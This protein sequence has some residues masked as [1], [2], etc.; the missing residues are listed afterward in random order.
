MR[1][2][3]EIAVLILVGAIPIFGDRIWATRHTPNKSEDSGEQGSHTLTGKSPSFPEPDFNDAGSRVV[4]ACEGAAR[5]VVRVALKGGNAKDRRLARRR[6][7][8]IAE[9]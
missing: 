9:A 5:P 2:F 1:V 7:E 8:R 4:S 3:V 6:A